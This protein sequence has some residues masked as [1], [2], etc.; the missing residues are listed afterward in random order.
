MKCPWTYYIGY[1]W[2]C[3]VGTLILYVAKECA[4]SAHSVGKYVGQIKSRIN[5]LNNQ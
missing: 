1:V 5:A 4:K 3:E 2:N